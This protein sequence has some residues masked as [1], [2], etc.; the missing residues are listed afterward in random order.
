VAAIE[1]VL[2]AYEREP[3]EEFVDEW[4]LERIGLPELQGLFGVSEHD[5]MYDCFPVTE[6]QLARLQQA[7]THK[8]DLERFDYFV[9]AY[10][11]EGGD[12]RCPLRVLPAFPDARRVKP[13]TAA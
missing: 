12:P 9:E 4:P 11:G 13:R 6:K 3:G 5:P 2:A 1:R 8:I 10:T 7:V